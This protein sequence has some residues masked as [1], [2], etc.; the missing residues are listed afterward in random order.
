M[1][2]SPSVY[3]LAALRESENGSRILP[4]TRHTQ[5]AQRVTALAVALALV[6]VARPLRAE[7][8]KV[9]VTTRTDMGSGY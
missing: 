2:G 7:V 5:R 6:F 1:K 8:T 9:D 4:M 3:P